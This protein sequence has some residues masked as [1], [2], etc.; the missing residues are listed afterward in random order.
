VI[1]LTSVQVN[2]RTTKF[3]A[4][5]IDRIVN[6]GYFRSRSEALNEAIRIL[7][8]KYQLAKLESKLVKAKKGTKDLPSVTKTLLDARKEEDA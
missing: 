6:E 1:Y 7:I 8:R 3:L 4:N 2:I 5:E